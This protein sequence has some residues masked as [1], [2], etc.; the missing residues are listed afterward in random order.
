MIYANAATGSRPPGLTTILNS[1]RQL[2]P[3]PDEELISYEAGIKADLLD[4]RLRVNLAAFYLDYK[5]LSTALVGTECLSE[6]GT[7]SATFHNVQF[8]TE[9]AATL[10]QQLYGGPGN[11]RY[12]S[13][14]GI[15]AKVKGF[16]WEITAIPVDGLRLGWSGGYN[17]YTSGITTPGQPGYLWP[18]NHRQSEWSMHADVS[19]E[20]ETDLVTITPRL[21]WNWQSQQDYDPS[22][23]TREP[24]PIYIIPAYSMWNAQLAYRSPDNEWSATL[25]VSNLANRYVT[26]PVV[27]AQTNARARVG[28]PR[29]LLFTLRKNF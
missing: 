6:P 11:I 24:Q 19:Y 28:P 29:E 4:R 25:S 20:L 14:I 1:A 7:G 23:S 10:C 21:D 22:S 15:P 3:T 26:Y 2:A 5:K 16:E 12:N 17:K 13:Y 8:Q 18:G 27:V 9:A